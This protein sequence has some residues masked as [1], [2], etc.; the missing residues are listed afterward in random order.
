MVSPELRIDG[1][2]GQ[3]RR[4]LLGVVGLVGGVGEKCLKFAQNRRFKG[5]LLNLN[6]NFDA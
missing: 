2:I 6:N 4:W 3:D 5:I 1:S